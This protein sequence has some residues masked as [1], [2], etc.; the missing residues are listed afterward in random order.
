MWLPSLSTL[1]GRDHWVAI[2]G[3]DGAAHAGACAA[4]DR[5][6]SCWRAC[7]RDPQITGTNNRPLAGAGISA[8][9]SATPAYA[10][11]RPGEGLRKPSAADSIRPS[12][13]V[14]TMRWRQQRGGGTFG[15]CRA[16]G[17]REAPS[18][19]RVRDLPKRKGVMLQRSVRLQRDDVP[20]GPAAVPGGRKC[21]SV[22]RV[23]HAIRARRSGR[24]RAPRSYPRFESSRDDAR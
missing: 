22:A 3:G 23:P 20:R 13:G 16:V 7:D 24:D 8:K 1:R 18:T 5:P 12:I 21:R 14:G 17:C 10:G 6:E 15:L 2:R 4:M 11:G 19:D 9:P